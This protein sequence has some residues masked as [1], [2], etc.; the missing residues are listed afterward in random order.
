MQLD[1]A[2]LK[3]KTLGTEGLR[4]SGPPSQEDLLLVSVL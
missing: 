3:P 4:T 1:L 2:S